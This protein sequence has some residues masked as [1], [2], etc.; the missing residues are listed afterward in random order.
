MIVWEIIKGFG[1]STGIALLFQNDGW[2]QLIMI[3]I[4][5]L[6]LYLAV[7]KEAEPYLLIPIGFG[8]LLVNLPGSDVYIKQVA[9]ADTL[10]TA[11]AFADYAG[12]TELNAAA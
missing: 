8:M 5:V 1:E 2:K 12:I 7:F 9:G 10:Y 4:A 3:A 11:S 6:L